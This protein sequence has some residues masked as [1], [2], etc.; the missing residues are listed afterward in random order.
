MFNKYLIMLTTNVLLTSDISNID[1]YPIIFKTIAWVYYI[2]SVQLF[3]FQ[4]S[5]VSEWFSGTRM[6]TLKYYQL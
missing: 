3:L 5:D 4:T 6:V 2:F 1:N